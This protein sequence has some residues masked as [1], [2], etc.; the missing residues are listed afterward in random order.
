MPVPDEFKIA[1]DFIIC[2]YCN[3]SY[4][5]TPENMHRI[6][7]THDKTGEKRIFVACV[8]C[9][10]K[11]AKDKEY[12]KYITDKTFNEKLGRGIIPKEVERG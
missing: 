9:I 2:E 3:K 12:D 7:V 6:L 10:Q 11:A 5:D 4:S 8:N 1:P